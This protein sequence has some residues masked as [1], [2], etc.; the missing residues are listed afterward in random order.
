MPDITDMRGI[1]TLEEMK[2]LRRIEV[3]IST[4]KSER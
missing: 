4:W 3:S 2:E 1:E